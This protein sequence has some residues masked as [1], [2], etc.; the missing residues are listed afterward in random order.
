[1]SLDDETLYS[2]RARLEETQTWPCLYVFKFIVLAGQ[3]DEVKALFPGQPVVV[4]PS[5]KGKYVSV[6]VDAQVETSAA[7]IAVYRQAA[8]I[9]GILCL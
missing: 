9:K 8:K 4:R 2:L 3:L 1:M 7:V 5:G 6:T